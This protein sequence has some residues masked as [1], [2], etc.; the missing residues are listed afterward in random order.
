MTEIEKHAF[1]ASLYEQLACYYKYRNP[2]KY[3]E[4]Y[5]KH[6]EAVQKLVQA[7]EQGRIT[8]QQP[9]Q[10]AKV[11]VL[12][13]S[14][15]APLVDIYI[16]GQQVLQN[17]SYKQSSNYMSLPQGQYRIDVYETGTHTSPIFS[18]LVPVMNNKAYTIAAVGD[19]SSKLQ[20]LPFI[21]S[22]FLPYGDAKIRVAHLSPDAPLIDI[23]FKNGETLF[24]NL[25][26]KQITEYLQVTSGTADLEI[27]A[28]GTKD[29]ILAVPN[30]K[31]QPN[32]LYTIH[33]IGFA[34]HSPKLETLLLT[35]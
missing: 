15:N 1:D 10:Q 16:N 23:A 8:P 25:S 26:Y 31:I 7:Y 2:Q 32:T 30:L 19:S 5:Y 11:R 24:S 18:A 21:D 35:N 13:A 9:M 17:I 33:I 34:T 6:Y 3:V 20:L 14:P 29:I 22:T 12:H 4:Y 27:R 28:A